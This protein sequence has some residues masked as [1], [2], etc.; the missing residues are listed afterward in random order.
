[1]NSLIFRTVCL[2]I[3]KLTDLDA[4][5]DVTRGT[6]TLDE[7]ILGT[8]NCKRRAKIGLQYLQAIF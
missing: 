4:Q 6:G 7:H 8:E 3:L 1:M 2:D 5:L